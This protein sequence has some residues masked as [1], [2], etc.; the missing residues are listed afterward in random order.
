ME[1]RVERVVLEQ[2]LPY[3]G[4]EPR[5]FGLLKVVVIVV[6]RGCRGCGVNLSATGLQRVPPVEELG[7]SAVLEVADGAVDRV[8][9]MAT[10]GLGG[11]PWPPDAGAY[12]LDG[13]NA[14]KR[15]GGTP[16]EQR[17]YMAGKLGR[18]EPWH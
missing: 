9:Q 17:F 4:P 14:S 11:W 12:P 8:N 15:A 1:T 10:V 7:S 6:V 3:V 2:P 16:M 18:Q 5:D 13:D